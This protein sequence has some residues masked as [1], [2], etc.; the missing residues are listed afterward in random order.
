MAYAVILE[1]ANLAKS[2]LAGA[3][4][5]TATS[6]QLQTGTGALFPNPSS[7]EGYVGTF[8]DA[9]TGLLNEI[10]LVTQ[11][12]GD[13]ITTMVRAQEG[14]TALG[15]NAGDF[16]YQF[17]TAGTLAAMLQQQQS[18]PARVV[19][20]S[21]SFTLGNFDGAVGLARVSSLAP[22]SITM[23]VSPTNG[24][25]IY[26]EDLIGNFNSYPVTMIPNSGQNIAG[27]PANALLN[28]NRQSARLTFYSTGVNQGTWSLGT[29]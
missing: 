4:S 7:G 16:F 18:A 2:T 6:A 9:A 29:S 24:Q 12:T 22:T 21:A 10:V 8:I 14:T 19:T 5:S 25:K 28:I 11:M 1:F 17:C 3:I 20:S 13:Q 23:P 15:W 27:L 26:I